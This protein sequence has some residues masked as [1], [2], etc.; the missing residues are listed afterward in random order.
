MIKPTIRLAKF[1]NA[2]GGFIY[3]SYSFE[4]FIVELPFFGCS[5]QKDYL[6]KV[7]DSLNT[8][9][10]VEWRKEQ[11]ERAKK[12]VGQVRAYERAGMPSSA[13]IEVKKLIPD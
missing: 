8:N 5:N 3:D 9:N 12:V 10:D 1:W 13:E 6:F 7:I 11:I 4:K 2:H